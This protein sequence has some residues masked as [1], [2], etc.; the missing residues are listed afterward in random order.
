M[1]RREHEVARESRLNSDASCIGISDLAHEDHVGVLTKNC[2]EACG[3]REAGLF[4]R[5]DLVD[6]REHVLDRILHRCHVRAGRVDLQQR[7][8]ERR[9]LA[10]AGGACTDHHAE[11]RVD[12]LRVVEVGLPRE[13]EL[14]EADHRTALVEDSHDDLLAEDG[15]HAGNAD[16]DLLGVDHRRELAVLRLALLD[17]VHATHDLQAAGE[18]RMHA[19]GQAERLDQV[20]VDTESDAQLLVQR[21]HVDV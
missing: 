21:L 11:R 4:V 18:G 16:V 13:A 8:V 5:L 20:T 19:D 2:L 7:G 1:K 14:R 17:D 9:G 12:H 3:E 6:A 15:R 10:G